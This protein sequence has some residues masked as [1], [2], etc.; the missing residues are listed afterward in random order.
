MVYSFKS[1][2]STFSTYFP[3]SQTQPSPPT[4]HIP[5]LQNY[6]N[7]KIINMLFRKLCSC[8][9]ISPVQPAH[10]KS[11]KLSSA[12]WVRRSIFW[13]WRGGGR[14][15]HKK[16]LLLWFF[17]QVWELKNAYQRCPKVPAGGSMRLRKCHA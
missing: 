1:I 5:G 14:K 16:K 4:S 12:D 10:N 7:M 9:S 2:C 13:W 15:V 11:N 3:I 8:P 17:K 6:G